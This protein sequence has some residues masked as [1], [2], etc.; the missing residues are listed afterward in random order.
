MESVD[1]GLRGKVV[2]VTGGSH[3]LG[4]E[5]ARALLAAGGSVLVS[6]RDPNVLADAERQLSPHGD[7]VCAVRCDIRDEG[8]VGEMVD[9]AVGRFGGIDGLVNNSGVAGPTA[10]VLDSDPAQW[11]DAVEVNLVGTYLCCRAVLPSMVKA[12]GGSIVNI[13]TMTA[14]RPLYG[15]TSYAAGKS[16]LIGF[17]RTL[18]F[19]VGQFGIRANVV[20]PG[21]VDG[22]RMD[23]VFAAQAESR[24]ISVDEA[25]AEMLDE[26]PLRKLTPASDVA[27]AVTFLMGP[28]AGSI[29]G[30]DVNVSAG[31]VM[32]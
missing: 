1:D 14:K 24:G 6:G 4:L 11:R 15:R 32:Y 30:E 21:P 12:G 16:G 7:R 27:S 3:G 25:R 20:S 2:L 26:S 10:P 23:R 8:Q 31:I 29:T 13:G 28:G 22:P 5:I 19:E 17:T 9:A 18:A